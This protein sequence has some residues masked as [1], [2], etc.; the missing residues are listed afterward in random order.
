MKIKKIAKIAPR[1]YL[2]YTIP[3]E[4]VGFVPSFEHEMIEDKYVFK[5]EFLE[6]FEKEVSIAIDDYKKQKFEEIEAPK[7]KHYQVE[8]GTKEW[9]ELR[10]GIITASRTPFTIEGKKIPTFK[11]YIAEKVAEKIRLERDIA[12]P[13]KKKTQA[14]DDG[15]EFEHIAIEKYEAT[16]D[17]SIDAKG[18]YRNEIIGASP[19]GVYLD[20]NFELVNVEVKSVLLQTYLSHLLYSSQ[21]SK[22]FAQ[23]QVQMYVMNI[24]KTDFIVQCSEDLSLPNIT[25]TVHL[26]MSFIVNMIETLKEYE[27]EYQ[28]MYNN[29]KEFIC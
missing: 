3:Q 24:K 20:D 4:I 21:T 16:K 10:M 26:D 22:Y 29:F 5:K 25:K 18:I 2:A 7:V 19:D 23:M 15:N 8:Q 1:N 28:K 9:L 13:K 6:Q 17:I 27:E 11:P 12:V 14:M